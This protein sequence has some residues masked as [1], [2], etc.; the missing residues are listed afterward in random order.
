VV[1]EAGSLPVLVEEWATSALGRAASDTD[2]AITS[3]AGGPATTT[4]DGGTLSGTIATVPLAGDVTASA[5][6]TALGGDARGTLSELV[7]TAAGGPSTTNGNSGTV[8][9]DIVDVPA[10]PRVGVLGHAISALGRA[11]TETGALTT[12]VTGGSDS[13]TA[14]DGVLSGD[15]AQVPVAPVVNWLADAATAVGGARAGAADI[16]PEQVGGDRTTNG[17]GGSLSGDIL[18]PGAEVLTGIAGDAINVLG[19]TADADAI[20][21]FAGAANGMSDTAG[22]GTLNG[23]T[24]LSPVVLNAM[25]RQLEV[26]VGGV[27]TN[28]TDLDV[29]GAWLDSTDSLLPV[30]ALPSLA[31]LSLAPESGSGPAELQRFTGELLPQSD[32]SP[33]R[34]PLTELTS[35]TAPVLTLLGP[36]SGAV[37][38][39]SM[40]TLLPAMLGNIDDAPLVLGGLGDK[41]IPLANLTTLTN[42]L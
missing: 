40:V 11:S 16:T 4:G 35:L 32:E 34:L 33:A 31:A 29:P 3:T 39:L 26:P 10:G 23:Q 24:L 1:A 19:N 8:S 14:V 36:V 38:G 25:L 22:D 12:I 30:N 5:I 21:G 42:A 17:T 2:S 20:N 9:G 41:E 27:V 15:I 37:P 28:A 13:T 7:D 18:N 6:N